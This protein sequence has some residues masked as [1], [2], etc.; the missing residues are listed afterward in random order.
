METRIVVSPANRCQTVETACGPQ[1]G[2]EYL[3]PK[4]SKAHGRYRL[5]AGDTD[6][7]TY[8]APA[9]RGHRVFLIVTAK[10]LIKLLSLD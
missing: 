6:E 10:A 3:V 4:A 2:Q 8:M 7:R 1:A 9:G 5:G